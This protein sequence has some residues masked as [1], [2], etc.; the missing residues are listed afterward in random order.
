MYPNNGSAGRGWLG[1]GME[2]WVASDLRE[3]KEGLSEAWGLLSLPVVDE[4]MAA[5]HHP[6]CQALQT[7]TPSILT[8][9]HLE[10]EAQQG[11][12]TCPRSCSWKWV[13]FDPGAH[14]CGLLYASSSWGLLG[15]Q[16]PTWTHTGPWPVRNGPHSRR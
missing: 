3:G 6:L 14:R 15:P 1:S 7:Q 2:P 5:A 11:A 9:P 13:G 16:S 10:T 8:A 12:V 4:Y